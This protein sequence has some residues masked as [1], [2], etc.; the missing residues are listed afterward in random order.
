MLEP[1]LAPS[2]VALRTRAFRSCAATAA[3][4]HREADA[5]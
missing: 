1:S 5:R 4:L 3:R 2:A